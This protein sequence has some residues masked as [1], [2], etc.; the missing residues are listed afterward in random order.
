MG[1]M[2]FRVS[3]FITPSLNAWLYDNLYQPSLS[4]IL[5]FVGFYGYNAIY[6]GF[7]ARSWPVLVFLI[8]TVFTMFTYM[9]MIE[10]VSSIPLEIGYWLSAGPTTAGMRGII[11]GL[12]VGLIALAVRTV[13]GHEKSFTGETIN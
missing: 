12:A 3:A 8:A 4:T 1:G 13:L 10:L 6:S 5:S 11:I 9:P 7:K 2:L